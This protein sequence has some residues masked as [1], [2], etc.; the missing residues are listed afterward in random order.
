M[1]PSTEV[2][3]R[4]LEYLSQALGAIGHEDIAF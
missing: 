3:N 4:T 2:W 1:L